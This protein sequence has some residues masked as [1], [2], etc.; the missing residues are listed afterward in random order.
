MSTIKSLST[1][2]LLFSCMTAY[3][4]DGDLPQEA[5]WAM[6]KVSHPIHIKPKP[7]GSTIASSPQGITPDEIKTVY[8]INKLTN[9][10][11]GQ[12]IAIVT[13][14]DDPYAESD[15]NTFSTTFNLPACTTANG[16]FKRI[17]GNGTQPTTSPYGWAA[18]TAMDI[19]WAHAIAPKA[20]IYL[21]EANTENQ[22]DF[23]KAIQVAGKSGASVVSLSWGAPEGNWIKIFKLDDYF[24]V[25]NVSFVASSGDSGTGVN[26][27]AASPYVLSVGGTTLN[28]NYQTG[29][30]SSEPAWGGSGGGI[31]SIEKAAPEQVAYPLPNNPQQFRGVPDVSY[32]AGMAVPVYNS[33]LDSKGQR[34]WESAGGT[35]AAAPQWAG[36]IAIANSMA[37]KSIPVKSLLYT[38]AKKNHKMSFFDVTQ[39]NNG[40]CGYVCETH[41]DYD[42][43]TGLGTPHTKY[44]V[45]QL[46]KLAG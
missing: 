12:I 29:K 16:C 9:Q 7:V 2:V 31:S 14:Y 26:Y 20:K 4:I 32:N 5:S 38:I 41:P 21:V 28:I 18:E 15:L 17:Y 23:Y 45:N 37:H 25:P 10:G 39:G 1:G 19:E 40:T 3:A 43:V 44:L 30:R 22:P 27:P 13:P 33:V 36:I 11:E 24:N 6:P 35:S 8:G 46:V 42:Y 34:G